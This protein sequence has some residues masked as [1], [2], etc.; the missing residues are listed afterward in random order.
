LS[1]CTLRSHVE[2]RKCSPV[3]S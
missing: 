2:R 3:N 1:R